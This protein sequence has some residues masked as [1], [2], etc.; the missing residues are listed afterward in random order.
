MPILDKLDA[1]MIMDESNKAFGTQ[2]GFE[3]L[4]LNSVMNFQNKIDKIGFCY[5]IISTSIIMTAY[6]FER[7]FFY[8]RL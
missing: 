2:A 5:G 4:K 1:N 8:F 6:F 7:N 3:V